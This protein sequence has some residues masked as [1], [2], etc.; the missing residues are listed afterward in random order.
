MKVAYI[1]SIAAFLSACAT[2]YQKQG[3]TG[4][5]SE[6]Q[7]DTNVFTVTFKGN[8]YTERE[9]ATDFTLLRS[10]E[11]ALG[12]GFKYFII[13]D[14]E[15]YTKDS[16]YHSP[17]TI[18]TTARPYAGG[19][20][21]FGTVLGG[22]THVISKPTTSNTIVCFR[23]KPGG[24][25]YNADFIQTSIRAKYEIPSAADQSLQVASRREQTS[26]PWF[27]MRIE[28]TA[29][30][31]F[32]P[33]L[34]SSAEVT[35]IDFQGPAEKAGLMT[36]DIIESFNNADMRDAIDVIDATQNLRAG[37]NVPLR[38]RRGSEVINLT[39]TVGER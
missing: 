30:P 7:L 20:L 10:A 8:G 24:F 12:H 6:T 29:K 36:H 26:S 34:S 11:L 1:L 17:S 27:G 9:R 13:V 33:A 2:A 23:Q 39:M 31:R 16:M 15:K 18:I 25:S 4:G 32:S 28:N 37:D 22:H 21:G 19:V 3:Y 14:S 5:Y 38:V 35:R